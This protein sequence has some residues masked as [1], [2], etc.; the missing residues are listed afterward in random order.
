MKSSNLKNKTPSNII[1]ALVIDQILGEESES[2]EKE[3]Y[4]SEEEIF[5]EFCTFFVAGT[6]TTS[7]Y[8]L[9]TIYMIAKNP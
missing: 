5:E 9:M 3:K 2:Q 7:H 6:D 1:E 8:L 4:Y